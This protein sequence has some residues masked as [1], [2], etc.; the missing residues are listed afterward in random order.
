VHAPALWP[1]PE[2]RSGRERRKLIAALAVVVLALAGCSST[3]AATRQATTTA[4]PAAD[5]GGTGA[6]TT[7][8]MAAIVAA[9]MATNNRANA[10]ADVSLLRTYE[11]GSALS[12]DAASYVESAK[13]ASAC[14]NLPFDIKVLQS[15]VLGGPGYPRR[16]VV[17]GS[18][19]ALPLPKGCTAVT[20]SC[21]DADSIFEFEQSR[22]GSPWK[23]VL[24]P[25][26]DTGRIVALSAAGAAAVPLTARESVAARRLPATIAATLGNY[27][28]TGHLGALRASEFTSACWLLPNPRAS[29]EQYLNS[30]VSEQQHYSSAG[31]EVSVRLA[32]GGALSLFTLRFVTTLVP[33]AAGSSIDWISD[34][35]AEPVTGLLPSGQY[36]RIVE[37]GLLELAAETSGDGGFTIVGAY[38]GVTSV[39]GRPG[40]KPAGSGGG[41]LVSDVW[42]KAQPARLSRS[43]AAAAS[44]AAH[45]QRRRSRP[46]AGA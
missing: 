40:S 8:E 15:A 46:S 43:G 33:N 23:I 41:I 14:D 11:A 16:F 4:A 17:L 38:S 45:A 6:L 5:G 31:D 27:G 25:S 36:A 34:P 35:S 19:Y 28:A 22:P 2:P 42:P 3:P 9:T 30:G 13:A 26:A 29:F 12:I 39:A 20:S 32:G 24:E 1:A 18:S 7:G 21:P 44:P 37:R 10:S